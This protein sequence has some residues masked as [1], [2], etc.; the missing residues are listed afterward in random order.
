MKRTISIVISLL[1]VCLL[2]APVLAVPDGPVITMQPQS[3]NYPNYSVA[4]YTVKVA[5]TNLHATWYLEWNGTTY[6]LSDN[7]NGIEPWEAYAG[8]AYGATQPDANTFTFFFEGI[9]EELNGALIWCVIEDGH[10]DVTS[11]K[12]FV[13]VGN[14]NTPPSIVDMPARLIVEQGGEAVLRCVATAPEGTQLSYLWY[15]TSTGNMQDIRAIDRG[16]EDS[17]YIFCDT[18][19]LGTRYYVCM[20]QTSDGGSAYSSI[21]E[22]TVTEKSTETPPP[23]QDDAPDPS[24]PTESTDPTTPTNTASPTEQPAPSGDNDPNGI[25]WWVIALIA[26]AGIGA[27]I[28]VGALL[29]RKKS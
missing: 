2:A 25:D 11:Q 22:V 26:A 19:A 10:Y 15:E 3:P 28:G 7:Q 8:E 29:V 4:I 18:D 1:L 20:V 17:D 13:T 16:A 24:D 9:E 6:N 21:T 12:A 27:G 5:G 14:P 23:S